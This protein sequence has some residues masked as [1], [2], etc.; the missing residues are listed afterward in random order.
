MILTH[1]IEQ[2]M[3]IVNISGRFVMADAAEAREQFKSIIEKG[4]GK[5]V[6]D[7]SGVTF[8]D[9]SGVSV[10]ISAYK[11]VRSKSNDGRMILC[12]IPANVQALLELTRLNEIFELFIDTLIAM[13][14]LQG[15]LPVV[16]RA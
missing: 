3:D 9:T 14:A 11:A 10:L 13:D 2:D 4:N 8:M 16:S 12:G 1:R 5:L 6:V 7:L 15:R